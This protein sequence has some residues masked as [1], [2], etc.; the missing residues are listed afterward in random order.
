MYNTSMDSI[1]NP[2]KVW[3]YFLFFRKYNLV[4]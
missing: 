4:S 3:I 2:H 1:F